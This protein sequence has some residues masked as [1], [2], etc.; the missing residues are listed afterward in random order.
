MKQHSSRYNKYNLC[1]NN[2][3]IPSDT[4]SMCMGAGP[5][6]GPGHG[7]GP[8]PGGGPVDLGPAGTRARQGPV[9]GG[10]PGPG[11]CWARPELLCGYSRQPLVGQ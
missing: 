6:G 9:P 5:G 11:G 2:N 1:I 7:G 8:G 10:G 4:T 3:N